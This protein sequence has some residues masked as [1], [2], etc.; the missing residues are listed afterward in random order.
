MN[1]WEFKGCGRERG[2]HNEEAYGVCPAY[3]DNGRECARV[4]GTLCSGEVQGMFAQKL[5]ACLRC[6]YY[7][8]PHYERTFLPSSEAVTGRRE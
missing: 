7:R 5:V 8:S 3:P 2:G 6:D 4:A 1:C